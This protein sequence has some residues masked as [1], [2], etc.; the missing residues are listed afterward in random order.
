M[1]YDR[2]TRPLLTILGAGPKRTNIRVADGRLDVRFGRRFQMTV[3]VAEIH[4]ARPIKAQ[5][6]AI[7]MH[8]AGDGW[9][10]NGSA[11]GIVELRF[12]RPIA[13]NRTPGG[14]LFS[15]PV[16]SLR[17][18]VIDPDRFIAALNPQR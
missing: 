10:I 12:T 8:L 18:S 3:P 5:R 13:P 16:R 6:S 15:G 9:L 11:H 2:W 4:V 17:L 7:G 1:R 14:G